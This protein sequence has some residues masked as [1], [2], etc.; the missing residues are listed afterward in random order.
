MWTVAGGPDPDFDDARRV[1]I[2]GL[3][4]HPHL[5]TAFRE[6][7]SRQDADLDV[8]V[9]ELEYVWDCPRDGTANVVGYLCAR[10]G[11]RRPRCCGVSLMRA[12][13]ALGR[14]SA[15]PQGPLP[16]DPE[17]DPDAR[18]GRRPACCPASPP[19][20]PS[21]VTAGALVYT[22]AAGATNNV[23]VQQ[24]DAGAIT[25][26]TG[27]GDAMTAIPAGCAQSDIWPGT[28]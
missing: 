23:D 17:D 15:P 7:F 22:A 8:V 19:P 3:L 27:G 10:C 25:F 5:L 4:A 21:P 1:A 16:H 9:R 26:Y 20:P 18:R 6:Y 24:D 11:C 12:E 14:S 13:R 2:A 28:S